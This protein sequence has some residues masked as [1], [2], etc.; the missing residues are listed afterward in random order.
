M[1]T[2]KTM[3]SGHSLSGNGFLFGTNSTEK[4]ARRTVVN[5]VKARNQAGTGI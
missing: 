2:Y 3:N 1:K 5:R 4:N